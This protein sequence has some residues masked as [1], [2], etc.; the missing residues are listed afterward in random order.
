[1]HKPLANI[2]WQLVV[3]RKQLAASSRM[4]K[5]LANEGWL[6]AVACASRRP[7][8][9]AACA[10]GRCGWPQPLTFVVLCQPHAQ[11]TGARH[12]A[13]ERCAE[14]C[15]PPVLKDPHH[16]APDRCA[17][18]W[19]RRPRPSCYQS[20]IHLPPRS[21]TTAPRMPPPCDIRLNA[22]CMVTDVSLWKPPGARLGPQATR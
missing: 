19:N 20:T 4:R 6:L 18:A 10:A 22:L 11:A 14:P 16:A 1:M 2:S 5:H 15:L 21:A 17:K 3:A 13:H 8:L 7:Q 9:V 12:A